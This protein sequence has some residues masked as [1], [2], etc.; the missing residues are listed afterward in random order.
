MRLSVMVV[1][2][3]FCCLTRFPVSPFGLAATERLVVIMALLSPRLGCVVSFARVAVTLVVASLLMGMPVIIRRCT[4]LG[5]EEDEKPQHRTNEEDEAYSQ[6]FFSSH[7]TSVSLSRPSAGLL[8]SS[9]L[10]LLFNYGFLCRSSP[11]PQELS[12]LS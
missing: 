1:S 5:R 6:V 8:E 4:L 10:G 7:R 9:R 3:V 11:L 12:A 2:L